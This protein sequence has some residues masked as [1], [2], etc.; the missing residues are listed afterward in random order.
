MIAISQPEMGAEEISAVVRVL[1]SG[2]LSQGSEVSEFEGEFSRLAVEGLE[3]IAVNSGTSALHLMLLA[4]GIGAGDEVIVPSFT[5]AATANAVAMT[6]ATP[7]FADI[8]SQTYCLDPAAVSAS[9]SPRTAAVM[10]VHLFGHPANMNELS[11]I[12]DREGLML[13]EDAAQA[14]LA[15]FKGKRVGTWGVA[16]A[17][18]FYP[19]KN[20]TCGEGGMAVTH[21]PSL[22]RRLRLLRNQG[23][24]RK[25]E[26]EIVGLNNRMTDVHAAIGRVQLTRVEAWTRKRQEHAN[27]LNTHLVGVTKPSVADEAQHVFHQ[28]TIQVEREDRDRFVDE[29][30]TLG[31]GAGVY[32]PTPVHSLPAFMAEVDLP[33]TNHLSQRCISLPV[34]PKLTNADLE[35]VVNSVNKLARAGS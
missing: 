28:Y 34:H 23:Q 27:F 25:Y 12:T 2:N 8:D 22:A 7:V 13:F 10:P 14:H 24:E 31:V 3:C 35:V 19:T 1:E 6:G 26:N 33:N 20:M 18:S 16:S 21:D 32:Y 9:I 5:F 17:F 30:R 11:L 4:A 29:L 15:T